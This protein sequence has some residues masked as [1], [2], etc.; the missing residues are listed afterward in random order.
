M[1]VLVGPGHSPVAP[2]TSEG[3]GLMALGMCVGRGC[4]SWWGLAALPEH[5]T[6]LREMDLWPQECGG[7]EVALGVPRGLLVPTGS[8]SP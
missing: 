5:W 7:W 3:N 6:P 4:G 1:A 8:L 2:D